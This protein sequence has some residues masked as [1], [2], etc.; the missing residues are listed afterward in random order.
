MQ[1]KNILGAFNFYD[2]FPG[3]MRNQ[4]G[5]SLPYILFHYANKLKTNTK[6]IHATNLL[7][8]QCLSTKSL[9]F[10]TPPLL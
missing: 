4:Y 5:L 2:Y 3:I 6:N 10:V 1:K 7:Y 9:N 8:V